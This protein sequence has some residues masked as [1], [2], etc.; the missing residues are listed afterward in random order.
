MYLWAE[1]GAEAAVALSALAEGGPAWLTSQLERHAADESRHVAILRERLRQLGPS[2]RGADRTP[3]VGRGKIARLQR[4]ARIESGRFR[5]GRRVTL[6]AVA[7]RL[8]VMGVRILERHVSELARIEADEGRPHPTAKVLRSILRDERHHVVA[9]DRALQRL[10]APDERNTLDLLLGKID[11][12]QR[13]FG[14]A[15]AVGMFAAGVGLQVR[16]SV[17][18]ALGRRP[19]AEVPRLRSGQARS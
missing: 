2:P 4:I 13:R 16:A 17:E 15:E 12:I 7:F 9:C 3:R 11:A 10:V 5:Q 14:V 1:E 18:R 19:V 6:L 8:E